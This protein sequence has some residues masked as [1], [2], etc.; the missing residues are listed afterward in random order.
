MGGWRRAAGRW[1]LSFGVATLLAYG[2][3]GRRV[4]W[5]GLPA[6][7]WFL[8]L[9]LEFTFHGPYSN[10]GIAAAN[11][12]IGPY[13]PYQPLAWT[14]PWLEWVPTGMWAPVVA[15]AVGSERL[16]GTALVLVGCVDAY[17]CAAQVN[18]GLHVPQQ[19]VPWSAIVGQ[20]LGSLVGVALSWA[21]AL[22]WKTARRPAR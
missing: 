18:V 5:W 20:V 10:M 19:G 7:K 4:S 14:Y 3:L 8:G 22:V 12:T 15:W 6:W 11:W 13:G 16:W 2:L 1:G 9:A 17:G 21:A